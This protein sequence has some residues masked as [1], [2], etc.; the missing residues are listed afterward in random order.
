MLVKT[1][2]RWMRWQGI[3]GPNRNA[4]ISLSTTV[5]DESAS[6]VLNA[7]STMVSSLKSWLCYF[8]SFSKVATKLSCL[9]L[10]L[11]KVYWTFNIILNFEDDL[12]SWIQFKNMIK[13]TSF[14][15]RPSNQHLELVNPR[16]ADLTDVCHRAWTSLHDIDHDMWPWW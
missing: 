2:S 4:L 15:L 7:H 6:S 14:K 12:V 3:R 9:S 5:F 11:D 8:R 10:L 13:K 1:V 16:V